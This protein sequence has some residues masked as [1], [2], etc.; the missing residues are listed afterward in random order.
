MQQNIRINIK[1]Q[2]KKNSYS[3]SIKLNEKIEIQKFVPKSFRS[4][5][6]Q[7]IIIETEKQNKKNGIEPTHT[8]TQFDDDDE[9]YNT[10][11]RW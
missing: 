9:A 2:Y 6:D 10:I 4:F 7:I 8:H 5:N 1:H 11:N 3:P